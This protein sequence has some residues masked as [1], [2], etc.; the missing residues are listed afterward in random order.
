MNC[1]ADLETKR[2]VLS[3]GIFAIPSLSRLW[4]PSV[5]RYSENTLLEIYSC[6]ISA[7]ITSQLL[8]GLMKRPRMHIGVFV[9]SLSIAQLVQYILTP[10]TS[11]IG[12]CYYK[13][14]LAIAV[15][16]LQENA[17]LAILD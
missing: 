6:L 4:G 5:D 14:R 8:L 12:A 11:I 10:R 7:T 13:T 15:L 1:Q 9:P 3:F 17:C 2:K 16:H